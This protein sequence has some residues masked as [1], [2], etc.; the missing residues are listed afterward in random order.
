M[1]RRFTAVIA[2]EAAAEIGRIT[3]WWRDNRPGAPGLFQ[4]EL[5]QAL[6]K[7]ADHPEIGPRVRLSGA[8]DLRAAVLRRT[9]Y[10]VVYAVDED[11]VRIEVL[12]VRHGKRRTLGFKRR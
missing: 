6:I 7:L 12:R 9:G 1:A 5:E 10:I 4:R 2:P 8:T 3:A 11:A